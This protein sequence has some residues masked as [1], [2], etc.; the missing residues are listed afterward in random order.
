MTVSMRVMS[1]GDG[2]KYLLRTVAAGDGD[3]DLSTPLTRYYNADGTPPGRW[4]GSGLPTLGS[5]QLRDSDEVTEAQLQLLIGMGRDPLTGAP[6]GRAYPAYKSV[7]QRVEE[8]V[9]TLDPKLGPTARGRAVAAIEAA[10]SERGTRRAVAGYDFTFSIPKSASVLWA[11]AEAGTQSLIVNAHHAAVA[12]VVAFME[13]E[14]AATR[15]GA[16]PGDGA[17]AQVEVRGLI[18]TAYD[19]YDSRAGDPHLHTHVVISNKVQ[20]VLDNKWRSLDGRPL[21][22]AT[23]A[24]SE[25]HEAVFA[26][27]LTRLFGVEWETRDRGRDRN[28]AWAIAK[29]PEQLVSEFSSRSRHINEEKDRLIAAYVEK[30]GRQPS[31]T[32]II[33]LRAQ[34]TL[35]TRPEKEIHSLAELTT[36]WR[37]RAGKILGVDATRWAREVTANEAPLLLR[38]DDVPLDVV[39]GLGQSVVATVGEKR[40]TWRRWNLTAEAARQTMKYRFASTRDREAIIGMVVDAAEAVSIRLTPP[41]LASSPAIFRRSDESSVF[42]PKNS[43]VFSSGELLDA[44]ERLLRLAHTTTGPTVSLETVERIV[45]KPDRA[46]LVLGED[47][48]SA[49][50]EIAVSGRIV[51]LL[52][53]PAGAGKTTAMNALRRAWEKEHGQGSVVGLAPSSSAAHVLAE[54]LGITTENTAK[55]WQNHLQSGASFQPGQLVIVD[56]ASL[57]GTLSLDRVTQLAAKARAKVL[58]VGDYAQLQAVDAGGAFGLLTH[59]RDDVP[60]LVDV[61][62][63]THDW[64]KRAS[65]DLRHGHTE[66]IDTYD[67]HN[68]I[69]DGD[70]ES[71]IDAAYAAWRADL[72]AG[73]AT[74]LVSDSNESVTA[75]NNRARTDLILDGTVWGAR[76]SELHDGT[77]AAC[78]DIVI[79]RRNDR[80]LLA[81]HGWVRNGDRWSVVDA[82]RD[83][84]ML[85]RRA[86]GSWGS[87]VL[88]PADYVAEH[89]ELGYAVTSF[90][91]Q[92]L[93]TGTAHVLVDSTMSRET[94]YVAMTRG[95]DAN[96]AYVAVDKPDP[97]H[98][99][100]H[101]GENDEVT[102][103]SVLTGV[104]QHVG[105]ELSAHETIAVEQESW[106]TIAQLAAEYE[107]IASA[108]QRDRWASL[109]RASGLSA[110]DAEEVV[111]S[112]A[113]GPL[114]AELRRA[115]ANHHDLANLLRRLV[116][117]RDFGD[118]D[119]IAAVIRHRLIAATARPAG[120][121]RT[122]KAPRLIA[123]L[124]PEAMGSVADDMRKALDERHGLITQR[125]DTVLDKDI[126]DG[127]QWIAQLGEPP[128]AA[129]R[130]EGWRL[131]ARTI[132]A[133]RDRYSVATPS[134][135]GLRP[136]AT[137][138]RIDHSRAE[139]ALNEI[140]RMNAATN[141]VQP[142]REPSQRTSEGRVR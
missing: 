1:A 39:R 70:T 103:R 34:A 124:V 93:T 61:H 108:A 68:R 52:V 3:R 117:A 125:A 132:A 113:F 139:A 63:F 94:F 129:S 46:G 32:T 59:D 102:G 112:D 69:V 27:H 119:D 8:R 54:D 123:G 36:E 15:A 22:A 74:V 138:Q 14:V 87:S 33:K 67:A 142:Y 11:V 109:V 128:A 5:G 18:A 60:E 12:E 97:S 89:V 136:E 19:H 81:G 58:L 26:D 9:G 131:A 110:E 111:G 21:H 141:G 53:G 122:R 20:T 40:S 57:A 35:A 77:H 80:R 41:E 116:R 47:Q 85:V 135:L 114:T 140:R 82:R 24:L 127:V 49:L 126:A 106:G 84:S 134:P 10:E 137:A 95:R 118:A 7:T 107:T 71:V 88:L 29:V 79:T 42:R 98:D 66:V 130:R 56:E 101:P 48:A 99:G 45:R 92:G 121:G 25:F 55:W 28:A 75:L 78:G 62:R 2:Y 104:L 16:T 38:A 6:L 105:A 51:D 96:V 23:V 83:G 31:R 120:S 72:V 43:T 44:E 90:R 37:H 86:G 30:H 73:R 91:A 65:L 76:E 17:V 13:R 4:M 50:M 100:P 115:E 133:Y 64:E